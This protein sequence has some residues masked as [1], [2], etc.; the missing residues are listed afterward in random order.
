MNA[1]PNTHHQRLS[2]DCFL[3]PNSL[4]PKAPYN[5]PTFIENLLCANALES[6]M[7][8][9]REGRM[10]R[11]WNQ[12]LPGRGP[13]TLRLCITPQGSHIRCDKAVSRSM[14]L[15]TYPLPTLAHLDLSVADRA[16]IVTPIF[17]M[18]KL[19]LRRG[20]ALD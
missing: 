12:E 13:R 3:E 10:R 11:Q 2:H 15:H 14:V 20:R 6:A 8:W 18:R 5:Q 19:K 9:R 4:P 7:V 1:L 17:E 16:G